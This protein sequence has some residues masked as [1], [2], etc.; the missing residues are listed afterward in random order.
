MGVVEHFGKVYTFEQRRDVMGKELFLD[1]AKVLEVQRISTLGIAFHPKFV[2]YGV[3]FISYRRS[4]EKRGTKVARFRVS[5]S[6]P[7]QVDPASHEV[8]IDWHSAGHDGG[9]LK[10]GPDGYLYIGIGDG[11]GLQ[12]PVQRGQDLSYLNS[13]ILRIDIDRSQD[14]LG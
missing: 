14:D 4:G 5:P 8:L 12:D 7:W 13:S 10:F 3:V 11:G 9:C 1:L 2:D 6:Q